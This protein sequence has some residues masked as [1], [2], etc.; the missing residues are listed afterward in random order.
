MFFVSDFDDEAPTTRLPHQTMEDLLRTERATKDIR[1]PY[2][3]R[4]LRFSRA[5]VITSPT[6]VKLP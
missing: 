4:R 1:P 6:G 3:F 5:R 2:A